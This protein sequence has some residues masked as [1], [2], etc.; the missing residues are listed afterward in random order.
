MD[1]GDI[2]EKLMCNVTGKT[3]IHHC[4]DYTEAVI[5]IRRWTMLFSLLT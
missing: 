2:M 3:P 1:L 4:C 5:L